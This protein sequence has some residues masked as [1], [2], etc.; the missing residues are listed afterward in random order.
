MAGRSD[1]VEHC[2]NSVVPEAR[3]TL[4]ARLLGK[5][6]VVLSFK[7]TN[8]PRKARMVILVLLL[9]TV[10]CLYGQGLCPT[11]LSSLSISSPNPGVSTMVRNIQVR[12]S[13]NSISARWALK[14]H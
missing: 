7:E 11:H 8:N 14:S 6:I 13:S 10:S 3:V 12:S 1:E 4:D 5:L 2:M 9:V